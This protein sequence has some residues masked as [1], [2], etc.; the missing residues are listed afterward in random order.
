MGVLMKRAV[1][2]VGVIGLA[3]ALVL[4]QTTSAA[5]LSTWRTVLSGSGGSAT[6]ST[7]PTGGGTLKISAKNLVPRASYP[8]G[9]YAKTCAAPGSRLAAVP[10]VKADGKGRIARSF[11]LSEA[12]AQAIVRSPAGANLRIGSGSRLRCGGLSAVSPRNAA[13]GVAVRVPGNDF[14]AAQLMTVVQAETW[15]PAP[16]GLWQPDPGNVFVTVLV[17]IEALGDVSYN[18]FYFDLRDGDGF[19]YTHTIGRDPSLSSGDLAAGD[20]V[21]GW[22]TFELPAG[23]EDGTT[24][25]YDRAFA[26]GATFRLGELPTPSS[27]PAP[28]SSAAP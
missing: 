23:S 28:T 21:Q 1:S 6:I 10:A 17:R 8:I 7:S 12:A 22:L 4:P 11:A 26:P 24:L 18:P 20:I 9:V 3:M 5:P 27:T 14:A 15:S 13:V 25:V 19:E 16:D 2:L